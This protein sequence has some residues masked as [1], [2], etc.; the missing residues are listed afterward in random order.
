[1]KLYGFPPS[2]NTWKVRAVAAHLGIPLENE[3]VDLTKGEQRTP[4]YLALNP[5]AR[6]PVLVDGDLKLWESDA[7]AQYIASQK[8]NTLW[9]DDAR[10]RADIMRWQSWGLAHWCKEACEPLTFQNLVK[11]ILKLGPPEPAVIAK[12]M[13][14][15]HREAKV[16]DAHLAKHKY[17]VGNDVTL[18]DFS[19][20]AMLLHAERGGIPV[21]P[22][23]NVREWFGRVTAL[24]CWKEAA[25]TFSAQA[26]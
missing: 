1:M 22:Y 21:A 14:A 4:A 16:L 23:A 12:A 7:I 8:P 9:P 26:A 2:P 20:A 11:Q 18:A 3:L 15:F 5:T 19:V 17:L 10:K 6:T 25:P 24:P 13:D